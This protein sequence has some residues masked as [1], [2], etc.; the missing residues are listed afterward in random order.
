MKTKQYD[1]RNIYTLSHLDPKLLS[2]IRLYAI[3]KDI[4]IYKAIEY[5]LWKGLSFDKGKMAPLEDNPFDVYVLPRK[6]ND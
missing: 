2:R 6:V 1:K 5:L 3:G 4:P